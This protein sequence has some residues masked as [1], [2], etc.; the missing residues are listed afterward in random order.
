MWYTALV[1]LVGFGEF[2]TAN[3]DCGPPPVI[4]HSTNNASAGAENFQEHAVILYSCDY[5]YLPIGLPIL[6]C[7]NGTWIRGNREFVCRLRECGNLELQHGQV[8]LESYTVGSLAAFSCDDGYQLHGPSPVLLCQVNGEWAPEAPTCTVIFCNALPEVDNLSRFQANEDGEFNDYESVVTSRCEDGYRLLGDS[9]S[10]CQADGTW[11]GEPAYCQR[12]DCGSPNIGGGSVST[13]S[14]TYFGGIAFIRCDPGYLLVGDEAVICGENGWTGGYCYGNC[15]VGPVSNGV[16]HNSVLREGEPLQWRCTTN[17]L[18][19]YP[20]D[21]DVIC[22]NGTLS[23]PPE[24]RPIEFGQAACPS[25]SRGVRVT[26]AGNICLIMTSNELPYESAKAFCRNRYGGR[27]LTVQTSSK[28]DFIAAVLTHIG[29]ETD[30][31][32]LGCMFTS[33]IRVW[34]GLYYYSD[35]WRWPGLTGEMASYTKWQSGQGGLFLGTKYEKCAVL[36]GGNSWWWDDKECDDS[37]NVVCETTAQTF[38]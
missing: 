1:V 11:S 32:G 14:G 4:D 28:M 35:A 8:T 34:I 5:L 20:V 24:C 10:V 25:E 33:D 22:H 30:C 16:S 19:K 2:L 23:P 27:L 3:A 9:V 37:Y 15:T 38:L 6:T 18:V 26:Q 17:S 29:W 13:A 7:A 12:I 36:D 21:R 31:S